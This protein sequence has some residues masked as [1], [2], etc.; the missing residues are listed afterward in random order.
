M[1]FFTTADIQGGYYGY[2]KTDRNKVSTFRRCGKKITLERIKESI[3]TGKFWFTVLFEYLGKPR[4]VTIPR[5]QITDPSLVTTLAA[6]GAD[7]TR[8]H[9]DTLVDSIRLQEDTLANENY[10]PDRVYEHLGWINDRYYD[11]NGNI[12]GTQLCYR[13]AT[14]VGGK[15]ATYVGPYKVTPMG[16]FDKWRDMVKTDVVGHT[17][18]EVVLIASL[19]AVV[20][21]L[22]SRHTTAENPIVHLNYGSRTGKTTTTALAGSAFGETFS[23]EREVSDKQG[24]FKRFKSIHGTWGATDNAVILDCAGNRGAVIVLNELG[25][26][27]GKDMS[28]LVFDLSEGSDKKRSNGQL[29]VTLSQGYDTTIISCGEASLLSRCQTKMDGLANRVLEI[30]KPLTT[31]AD[32]A[33][34][35]KQVIAEN[36]GHAAPML[37]KY[38][39]DSGGLDFALATYRKWERD[40]K[41]TFPQGETT[42][43]FIEKFAALFMATAEM[44]TAALGIPFDLKGL[45]KFFEDHELENGA[46]RNVAATSY[47]VILEACRTNINSFYR[48]GKGEPFGRALGK[49]NYP[50]KQQSNGLVLIEEYLVRQDFLEE[51]LARHHFPNLQTCARQWKQMGVLDYE[52]GRNTRSRHIDPSSTE[53]ENVYVFPIYQQATVANT[54]LAKSKPKKSVQSSIVASSKRTLQ[55]DGSQMNHL[56]SDEEDDPTEKEADNNGTH[57]AND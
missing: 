29:E 19:S 26:F 31:D 48:K 20:N 51:T 30:E 36:N 2:W 1:S 22:I 54:M 27:R 8:Q 37:A 49:V 57:H 3:E 21:G 9:F 23:G 25:K 44:A 47:E 34:R 4:R 15:P 14:L 41:A 46:R 28:Y 24:N 18:M 39:L 17:A 5:Q 12:L 32:H 40:L 42:G 7:A 43:S 52:K 50:N 45:Q 35:I 38:I 16:N 56:L 11:E 6:A 53:D 55:R 33:A 10:T 13:A